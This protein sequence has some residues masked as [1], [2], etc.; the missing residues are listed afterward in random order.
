MSVS[1]ND[2]VVAL[3]DTD[4]KQIKSE[5]VS[6]RDLT[7]ADDY[8]VMYKN[9]HYGV[10]QQE[11]D[12][13]G[14]DELVE[15]ELVPRSYF[16]VKDSNAEFD[17]GESLE[18]YVISDEQKDALIIP[19]NALYREGSVCYVYKQEG[20]TK[21]KTEVTVGTTTTSMVQI[22]DGI[23]EGDVVYVKE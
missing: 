4:R 23:G 16:D 13:A 2:F 19:S 8:Y 12:P 22:V 10:V 14:I 1:A 3:S 11:Y 5:F 20:N 15:Q 18:L 17:I 9:K 7:A 6:K 21:V